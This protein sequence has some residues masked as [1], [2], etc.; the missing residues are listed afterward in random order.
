MV[1]FPTYNSEA[2]HQ[3]I[4][5]NA[6]LIERVIHLMETDADYMRRRMQMVDGE[7]LSGDHSFKLAKTIYSDGGKPF[8]AMYSIMNEFGQVVAWWL[9]DGTQMGELK[10]SI[11]MLK[12]RYYSHGFEGV[13]SFTTDRCCDERGFWNRIF[14]F[15]DNYVSDANV[16]EEDLKSVEVVD[17]PYEPRTPAYSRDVSLQF[18]R[19]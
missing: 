10:A 11:Q 5:S 8:A 2:Y 6:Y 17:M 19:T 3:S 1:D 9:T 12:Q 14:S 16:P 4:P 15:L 13:K 7:H 18:I